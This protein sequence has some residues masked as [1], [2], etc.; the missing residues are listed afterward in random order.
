MFGFVGDSLWFGRG[1]GGAGR[2]ICKGAGGVRMV[3]TGIVEEVGKVKSLDKNDQGGVDLYVAASSTLDGVVLGDSISVNGT[4]LTVTSLPG[5]G[6][7]FGLAPETM[8]KTNLG[9][10]SKESGVNL[11][12]SL[13]ANGR[14]GGHIV[15]GHVDGTGTID[16]VEKEEDALWYTIKCDKSMMKYI[17]PKGYI[18]VDGT[19]LTVCDVYDDSFTFTMIAYTQEHVS[20]QLQIID[21]SFPSTTTDIAALSL[22]CI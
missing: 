12:R 22:F 7:T 5:D 18:A 9:D 19:S 8:R 10:L 6:F 14:M 11:E 15:Q 4:C 21:A 1:R 2:R 17:V 13:K 3:F 20:V 16:K